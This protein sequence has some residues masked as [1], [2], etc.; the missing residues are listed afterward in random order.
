MRP[1]ESLPQNA[2]NLLETLGQNIRIAR[3]RR[4]FSASHLAKLANIS[5]ETLRK[6]E[7]GHPGV[8]LGVALSVLWAL[9]LHEDIALL[10]APENDAYGLALAT[11]QINRDDEDKYD[12]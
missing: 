8:S 11:G 12:F 5:R 10:A 2:H 1:S 3:K 9:Q 7:K 4:K 6:L